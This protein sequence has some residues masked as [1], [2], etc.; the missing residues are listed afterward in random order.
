MKLQWKVNF[1][2]LI[3]YFTAVSISAAYNAVIIKD[4]EPIFYVRNILC[5]G[6]AVVTTV[7]I[8]VNR[9]LLESSLVDKLC[10][11]IAVFRILLLFGALYIVITENIVASNNLGSVGSIIAAMVMVDVD[12]NYRKKTVR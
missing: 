7:K 6:V 9:N 3:I 5:I 8:L 2:L 12:I 10:R 11:W 1:G 4:L